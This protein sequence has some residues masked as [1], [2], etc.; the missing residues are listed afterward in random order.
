MRIK[1]ESC[2][3]EKL[4]DFANSNDV[5]RKYAEDLER[6]L[7]KKGIPSDSF[8]L[9]YV[10]SAKIIGVKISMVRLTPVSDHFWLHFGDNIKD[11]EALEWKFSVTVPGGHFTVRDRSNNP[12]WSDDISSKPL[13]FYNRLKT[14]ADRRIFK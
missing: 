7:V 3:V 11:P 1:K 2:T 10:E 6:Y 8:L 13:T 12:Y 9:E 4:G 14:W 5:A